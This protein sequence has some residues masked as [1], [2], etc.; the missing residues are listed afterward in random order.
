MVSWCQLGRLI[1]LSLIQI[2][3]TCQTFGIYKFIQYIDKGAEMAR[4][5]VSSK[6]DEAQAQD[7]FA[8]L[9][10]RV[11][12]SMGEL[13]ITVKYAHFR[14]VTYINDWRYYISQDEWA[15]MSVGARIDA[16]LVAKAKA[17]EWD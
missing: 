3:A 2:L 10:K 17:E 11:G 16:F 7:Y 9:E 6:L 12:M 8:A 13:A 4:V 15:K 5:Q 1:P 14:D